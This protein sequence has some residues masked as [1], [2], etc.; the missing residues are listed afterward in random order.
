M[1][2]P[3]VKHGGSST[4]EAV[5]PER[6][7]AERRFA[8]IFVRVVAFLIPLV[9]AMVVTTAFGSLLPRPP[10]T[11]LMASKVRVP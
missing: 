3:D 1:S 9:L 8:A 6:R 10:G 5:E 7:W 2:A 4:S 11:V